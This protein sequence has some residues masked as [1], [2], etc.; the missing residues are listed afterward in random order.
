M[1][2]KRKIYAGMVALT[3]LGTAGATGALPAFASSTGCAFSNGC[4][5]LHGTDALGRAVAMDAKYQ[6]KSEILIGYADNVGDGATSFDGVLHYTRATSTTTWDDTEVLPVWP[7]TTVTETGP[8]TTLGINPGSVHL[9]AATGVWSFQVTGGSGPYTATISGLSDSSSSATVTPAVTPVVG[10]PGVTTPNAQLSVN[11][12]TLAPGVYDNA[13]LTITDSGTPTPSTVTYTF[14]VHVF[15]HAVT[16]PGGDA[17]YY[18]FVYAPAGTWS[19]Q[20]VTDINGSGALRL[21]P[22]TAGHDPGQDFTTDAT[23]GTLSATPAHISNLLAA[24]VGKSSCLTDPSVSNPTTPQSDAADETLT[25][26]RQLYVNGSCIAGNLWS[27]D[28]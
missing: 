5:T 19:S 4:A 1:S 8:S 14:L 16:I 21:Y 12:A 18:T 13:V 25:G 3:A 7:A 6:N 15:A 2:L 23:A 27:W 28:T 9:D 10:S 11:G 20:C 26:G 24:S 17:P 22:C